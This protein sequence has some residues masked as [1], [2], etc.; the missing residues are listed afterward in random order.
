MEKEY[1]QMTNDELLD[2]QKKLQEMFT[3]YYSILNE[4]YANMYELSEKNDRI[5]DILK[6]RNG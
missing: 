6:Q 2:E 1:E 3:Q 5:N 4:V